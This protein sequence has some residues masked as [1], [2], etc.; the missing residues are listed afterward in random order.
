MNYFVHAY[1]VYVWV[2]ARGRG[3]GVVIWIIGAYKNRTKTQW[4]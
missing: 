1:T 3:V 4:Q 2:S